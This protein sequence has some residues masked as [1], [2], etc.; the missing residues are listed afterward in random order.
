VSE[1]FPAEADTLPV[2]FAPGSQV[3]GYKLEEQ[4]GAGGMGVVFRARD[5]RL[6]RRVALKILAPGLEADEAFRHRFIRES[7]AAAAVDDPH[8]IP[9]FEAGEA[10]V[11]L[12]IAMRYVPGG[13][14]RTLI[15][16]TGPLSP[17]RALAIISPVASALDAA[18]SAGLVHRD[19]KSAN[20][21][22]DARPGR[23]DHVYL[24]D[25]GLSKSVITSVGST[26]SGQF[27]GT[28]GYSAPEQIEGKP[29]DGRADQYS[30]ACAAFEILCGETPFPRDQVM[31]MIWAH[32]SEPPPALTS[33]RPGLPPAVD[34]VLA[35]ALAKPPGDRYVSCREFADLLRQ[36]L[37]LAPYDSGSGGMPKAENPPPSPAQ[38]PPTIPILARPRQEPATEAQSDGETPAVGDHPDARLESARELSGTADAPADVIA[39]P[40]PSLPIPG[41]EPGTY[42]D[43]DAIP[44]QPTQHDE[45]TLA[46]PDRRRVL[47]GLAGA[48]A[49]GGLAAAGWEIHH[50]ARRSG[51]VTKSG[52]PAPA[53]ALRAG[54]LAWRFAAGA[55]IGSR[56][57]ISTGVV[58]FASDDFNV[59]AL[60]ARHGTMLWS[61]RT[62]GPVESSPAVVDGVVYIGS[63]DFNVYA[64]DARHGTMLWSFRTGGPVE[65]SPAVVDGVV[66]IG[67]QD[68][69]VYALNADNG[70]KLWEVPTA[71]AIDSSPAVSGG[72]VYIGSGDGSI[73][74]VSTGGTKLSSFT[75]SGFVD[76]SPAIT[77]GT[78]YAASDDGHVF[79][80]N[81]SNLSDVIWSYDTGGPVP[82]SSP[83]V[84][85]GVVY[86]GSH[87]DNVYALTA[88]HGRKI[89]SFPTG[90][91]VDSSP[92]VAVGA[93]Y[94]GS[95]DRNLYALAADD[96]KKLWSFPTSSHVFSSP[97]VAAGMVYV[98]SDDHH[99]YALHT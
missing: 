22:L 3:A 5:E 78:I 4:I 82:F 74:A 16:R 72:V 26:T 9:V 2:G 33:R 24:S 87:D 96:G 53:Q 64:L 58:Y 43:Q 50:L 90:G 84:I 94:I 60:D 76:S 38:S 39:A 85:G 67:S 42:S 52:A 40:L 75:T 7:R 49:V 30:L 98:G 18:H 25:F 47:V 66:Y 10:E 80:L 73:Y 57:T 37:G 92:A 1:M 17:G 54:T 46:G 6:Q 55:G 48:A 91:P 41:P 62:G 81:A 45:R 31:A 34:G 11:V 13:D 14:V 56:P 12:F 77:D 28:P 19:V 61:F 23:P 83:T 68:R 79:A 8:I 99:M 95:D 71:G 97:A 63:E 32:M 89:W 88:D 44:A 27:L 65:S 15:R 21:L 36:A 20:M 35:R 69:N 59:Y 51:S 70:T 86:I 93:V 29:V